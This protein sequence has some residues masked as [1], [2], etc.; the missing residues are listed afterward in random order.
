[1]IWILYSRQPEGSDESK[2]SAYRLLVDWALETKQ[3]YKEMPIC[4][5]HGKYCMLHQNIDMQ[6]TKKN[7]K[8]TILTIHNGND[9]ISQLRGKKLSYA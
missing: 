8:S 1:M 6:I 4:Y 9:D 2:S 7:K 3:K 5:K